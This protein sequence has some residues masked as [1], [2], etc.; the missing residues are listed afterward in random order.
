NPVLWGY[1]QQTLVH[2]IGHALGLEHPG[3]YNAGQGEITY[4][5]SAVYREDTRQYSVMSY[6]SE[7]NTGADFTKGGVHYY[8]G[9]PLM[10]DIATIQR[11]YGANMEAFTGDT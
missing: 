4:K 3:D 8:A 11:L 1:G 10:H 6:F 9:A 7:T 5:N 2:E